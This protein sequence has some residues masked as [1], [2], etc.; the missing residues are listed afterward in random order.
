MRWLPQSNLRHSVALASEVLSGRIVIGDRSAKH[1]FRNRKVG[2][3]IALSGYFQDW[4]LFESEIRNVAEVVNQMMTQRFGARPQKKSGAIHLRLGDYSKLSKVFGSTSNQYVV[5]AVKKLAGDSRD[6]NDSVTVFSNELEKAKSRLSGL[7]LN[8][9]FADDLEPLQTLFEI[10]QSSWI[11]G[12][13]ST[14]SW[15]SAAIGGFV[16]LSLPSPFLVSKRRN[17]KINLGSHNVIWIM[18]TV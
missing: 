5:E 11:V 16:P 1:F 7:S 9:V 18:R 3:G 14:F 2:S 6:S 13:N 10:S 8:F 4:T 15:W 17:A 12:S